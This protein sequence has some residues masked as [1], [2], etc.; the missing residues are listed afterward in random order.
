MQQVW[1]YELNAPSHKIRVALQLPSMSFAVEEEEDSLLLLTAVVEGVT[2]ALSG[3]AE[4]GESEEK[5]R[6]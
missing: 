2:G 6:R 3:T 4:A 5:S 1:E